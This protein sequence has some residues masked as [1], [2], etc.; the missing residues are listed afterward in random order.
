MEKK[1]FGYKL[2]NVSL[3]VDNV[4]EIDFP[5]L[6]DRIIIKSG[7]TV[8]FSMAQV[9]K[10][11]TVSPDFMI[12][13]VEPLSEIFESNLYPFWTWAAFPDLTEFWTPSYCD[14]V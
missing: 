2:K 12:I 10:N 8:E 7:D 4:D 1:E 14:Y 9:E 3:N 6:K 13:R 11:S 5:Q